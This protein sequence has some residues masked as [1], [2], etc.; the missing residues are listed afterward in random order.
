LLRLTSTKS[1]QDF[2]ADETVAMMV[3][4]AEIESRVSTRSGCHSLGPFSLH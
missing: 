4:T 2:N 1:G 3:H